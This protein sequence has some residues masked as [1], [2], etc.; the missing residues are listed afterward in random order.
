MAGKKNERFPRSGVESSGE[1]E[2]GVEVRKVKKERV[3]GFVLIEHEKKVHAI[4][5]SLPSLFWLDGGGCLSFVST[6]GVFGQRTSRRPRTPAQ[7]PNLTRPT[8]LK[9]FSTPDNTTEKDKKQAPPE[10]PPAESK[11]R[12]ENERRRRGGIF[13][14]TRTRKRRGEEERG[15]RSEQNQGFV[16]SPPAPP[17]FARGS[18]FAHPRV[19]GSQKNQER[20]QQFAKLHQ[21]TSPTQ[22]FPLLPALCTTPA[23]PGKPTTPFS[24]TGSGQLHSST[25]PCSIPDFVGERG[26]GGGGRRRR[27]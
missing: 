27:G 22:Q 26:E 18:S 1:E 4:G 24:F 14:I 19:N 7:A 12:N 20:L 10:F 23:R 13:N 15:S 3:G 5:G 21:P 25:V 2:R 8:S 11:E 6:E 9:P 16:P 17:R